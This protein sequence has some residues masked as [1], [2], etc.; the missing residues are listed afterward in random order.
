[1]SLL[2]LNF[3]KLDSIIQKAVECGVGKI[4]PFVSSR[5]I[6][7]PGDGEAKKQLRR[8]KIAAEAARQL[9]IKEK[10]ITSLR[11]LRRSIDAREDVSMV[12]TV[13]VTL[14]DESATLKRCRSKKVSRVAVLGGGGSSDV[15]A[16]F[17]AGADTYVSGDLKH[18]CLTEA[19]ERGMNLVAAGHFHTEDPVCRRLCELAQEADPKIIVEIVNSNPV[20]VI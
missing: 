4:I 2:S 18:S 16:A 20:R 5:C 17:R 1:M 8:Q 9:K 12:Y 3:F 11:V 15:D 13:E 19:P 6:A 10:E 7:R 14:K